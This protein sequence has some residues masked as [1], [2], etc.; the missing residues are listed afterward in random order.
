M[1]SWARIVSIAAVAG[2]AAVILGMIAALAT[3][4]H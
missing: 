4:G 3:S 1:T 2:A